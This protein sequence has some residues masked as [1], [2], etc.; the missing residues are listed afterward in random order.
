[1]TKINIKGLAKISPEKADKKKA[2]QDMLISDKIEFKTRCIKQDK[3]HNF[4]QIKDIVCQ[5]DMKY[6][7]TSTK[8]QAQW[9]DLS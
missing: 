8:P 1:M 6:T 4:F 9:K 3:E 2:M 7:V 5:E